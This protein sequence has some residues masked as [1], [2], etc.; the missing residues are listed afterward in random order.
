MEKWWPSED[1]PRSAL[2]CELD[3]VAD[4]IFLCDE[5]NFHFEQIRE[6][7]L[8]IENRSRKVT[9]QVKKKKMLPEILKCLYALKANFQVGIL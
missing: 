9:I 3:D 6:K 5:Q 2:N 8:L 1:N 7:E 4:Y